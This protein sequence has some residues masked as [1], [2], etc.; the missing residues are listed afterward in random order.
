VLSRLLG[1]DGRMASAKVGKLAPRVLLGAQGSGAPALRAL[2]LR[3][4]AAG[5][6]PSKT[7][8]GRESGRPAAATPP[9]EDFD[10][11]AFANT[12]LAVARDCPTG[13]F[14]GNKVFI[15]HVWQRLAGEPSFAALGPDAFKRQLVEAH[16]A[17]LLT[18]SRADLVSVMDPEDV[19][20][21]ET[22]YLNATFHFVLTD[23]E[24]P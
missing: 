23:K 11:A 24:Q 3:E 20:Q 4:W 9:P 1:A 12:V 10:L 2:A 17:D 15:S 5:D 22:H 19:R 18:L 14:G 16:R 21:S 7:L 8:P 6:G 13:R